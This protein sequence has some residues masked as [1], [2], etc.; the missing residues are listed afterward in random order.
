MPQPKIY[1]SNA[2][3]QAA[4]RARKPRTV[5]QARLAALARAI[6]W[7]IRDAAK[8][9]TLTLPDACVSEDQ[10]QTLRNLLCWLAPV[11]DTI[12]FPNWE[13]IRPDWRGLPAPEPNTL[14]QEPDHNRNS[15]I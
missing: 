4:Y 2:Q 3:R 8:R 5:T 11:K 12:R 15:G 14:K 13:S 6:Y 7:E 9:G 10:E 1:K